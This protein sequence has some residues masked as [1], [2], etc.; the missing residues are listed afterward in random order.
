[1]AE[2]EVLTQSLRRQRRDLDE[3]M[4]STLV[5][6]GHTAELVSRIEDLG[7]RIE[8]TQRRFEAGK[9]EPALNPD[10]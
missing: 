7:R 9:T 2:L 10:K 8:D 3:L 4:D 1:M 6:S 5:R